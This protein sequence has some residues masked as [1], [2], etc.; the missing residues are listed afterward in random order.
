MYKILGLYLLSFVGYSLIPPIR[1]EDSVRI[2]LLLFILHSLL[3]FL[4]L[5]KY[6]DRIDGSNSSLWILFIISRLAV[7][8]MLP[9]LSDDVFGYLWHGV[10]N[11]NGWNCYVY[12]AN[13]P[14]VSYLRN[15]LYELLAYK[16]HSAIYPP[17]A[18]IFITFGVW[19][20]QLFSNSWQSSLFGWK[21]ILFFAE[22]IGFAFL[23]KSRKYVTFFS[24]ALYVLLPISSIEILG[25]AHNDGLVIA[26][27]GMLIYLL[28]KN[29]GQKKSLLLT[30]KTGFTVGL[31]TL[32][33][34]IPI[35]LF[36]PLFRSQNSI[37]KKIILLFSIGITI[38]SISIFFFYD[39]RALSNFFGIIQFY[40]Q[41][42]F[43][44]PLLQLVRTVLDGLQIQNWWIVAP[45]VLSVI[46]LSCIVALG[47]FYRP[48]GVRG[49]M[50]QLLAVYT[51]ATIVSPKVHTWYFVPLLF[52]NSIVGWRWLTLGATGM[53]LTYTMYAVTPATEPLVLEAILWV[54]MFI[55]MLKEIKE[56]QSFL[57][58]T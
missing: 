49:V 39:K 22:A 33:K 37:K 34:L 8:P 16:T 20:G 1:T 15:E 56:N 54:V 30:W 50:M 58:N 12:P 11:I 26:P 5:K 6:S 41:T 52:L 55:Y 13:S 42:Q 29:Y 44:S 57:S 40:N 36:L 53:M 17:L 47:W 27:L 46:R 14:E 24:P 45:T 18:E 10:L 23:L 19:I 9:W 25:Q 35:V 51:V 28:A 38:V 21:F 31:M 4:I 32:L 2:F 48:S 7:Y 43:N 3:G